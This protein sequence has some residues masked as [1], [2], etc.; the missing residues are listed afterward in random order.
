[1]RHTANDSAAVVVIGRRGAEALSIGSDDIL[2]DVLGGASLHL[3]LHLID[4]ALQHLRLQES[5]AVITVRGSSAGG[6]AAV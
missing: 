5:H 1:M 2:P 4:I 6:A 3:L